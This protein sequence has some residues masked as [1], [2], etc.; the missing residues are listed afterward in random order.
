M[1]TTRCPRDLD[2]SALGCF[3]PS[4]FVIYVNPVD[5]SWSVFNSNY[6]TKPPSSLHW[7]HYHSA[8]HYI[9]LPVLLYSYWKCN[10]ILITHV[11]L[12]H[13]LQCSGHMFVGPSCIIRPVSS[14][15][16]QLITGPAVPPSTLNQYGAV[17][18][19]IIFL[20]QLKKLAWWSPTR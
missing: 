16:K 2:L 17:V 6:Y 9:A 13:T 14:N 10:T 4:S 1:L 20:P 12:A 19:C 7:Q 15:I 3:T 11:P 8:W 18:I 5:T